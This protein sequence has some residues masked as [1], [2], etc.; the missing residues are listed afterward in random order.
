MPEEAV[1]DAIIS[2]L[3][4]VPDVLMVLEIVIYSLDVMQEIV[5]QDALIILLLVMV[6]LDLS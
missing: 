3:E 2:F 6:P 5:I 1:R 4:E